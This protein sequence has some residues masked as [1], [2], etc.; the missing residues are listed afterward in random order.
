[1]IDAID[2]GKI[3]QNYINK[4]NKK[5]SY[6]NN[7][8]R[9]NIFVGENNSGKSR[10]LRY[11]VRGEDVK[12][13]YE[14]QNSNSKNNFNISKKELLNT[15][16]YYNNNSNNKIIIPDSFNNLNDSNYY[17]EIADY[18]E[19]LSIDIN[20]LNNNQKSYYSTIKSSLDEMYQYLSKNNGYVPKKISDFDVTYI[21]I[22]RGIENFDIYFNLKRSEDLD[23]I[24]M[25]EKQRKSLDEY[26]YNAKHIYGNKVSRA[27]L[28]N[29]KYIFTAEDLFDDVKD[30]LLGEEKDREFIREF[31]KFISEEFYD[32]KGFT[33]IPQINKGYLNV[34]IGNGK[35]RALHDLGDGIKQLI[36]IFYRLFE[37]RNDKAIF[38]IEE[39][40]LNLHPGYQRQ[41]IQILQNN[42]NFLKHQFFI[43]THSNHIIDNCLNYSDTSIYKFI[44]I[45][46]KNS[47]FKV[48]NTNSKDIDILELLGVYNSSVFMANCTIWVEGI[49]DKILI[50]RYLSLYLKSKGEFDYKEDIHYAFVE[51]GGNNITHWAFIDED[52]ISTI[53]ASAITNRSMIICDNDNDNKRK[54]KKNLLEIFGEERYYELKVREIENTLKKSVLERTIFGDK[55]PTIKKDYKEKDYAKKSVYMGSFIDEH[56][57]LKKSYS[58]KTTGTI[59]NKLEF[60]LKAASN[61]N[62]VEDLSTNAIEL[63]EKIY[64]FIKKSNFK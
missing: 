9:I 64:Q 12:A 39:P 42:S 38:F 8:S 46:E 35:E 34:K 11:I 48:I 56:Y 54:R 58:N 29:S 49:S 31:E 6:L 19:S 51:Y 37:K 14:F 16:A 50:S 43:T 62:E 60:A 53:N 57:N 41:F 24:V 4:Y 30:K 5:M 33:I 63:C 55:E 15:I 52:D 59:K 44:N 22:L 26:K 2:I 23:S 47:V 45:E 32:G 13:F 28:I 1:M 27:Y 25:N 18:F 17:C 20:T 3:S 7:L 36:T 10:L 40:E 21:P 61:L